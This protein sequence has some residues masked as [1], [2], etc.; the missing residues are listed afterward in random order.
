MTQEGSHRHTQQVSHRHTCT[1]H[2]HG[3]G[4]LTLFGNLHRHDG[5]RSEVGAMRQTFYKAGAEQE[6]VVRCY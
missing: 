6:P 4:S 3:I 2:R 1:H 5:T